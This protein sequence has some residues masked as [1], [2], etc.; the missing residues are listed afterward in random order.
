M[1]IIGILTLELSIPVVESIKEKRNI[2]RSIREKLRKKF[3]VSVAEIQCHDRNRSQI[4]VC[5]VSGEGVH[6]QSVLSNAYNL[7]ERFY[8]DIIENYHIELQ[9]YEADSTPFSKHF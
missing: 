9:D 5:A 1:M 2:T 4:A 8:P 3:N 6:L 7:I